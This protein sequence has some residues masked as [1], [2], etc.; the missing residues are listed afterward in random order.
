MQLFILVVAIFGLTFTVAAGLGNI[1]YE[2][3]HIGDVLNIIS[4]SQGGY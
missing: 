2:L 1:A 3:E 4:Q